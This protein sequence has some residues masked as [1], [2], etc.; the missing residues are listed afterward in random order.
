MSNHLYLIVYTDPATARSW[1][2]DEV[3]ERWQGVLPSQHKKSSSTVC[4]E[5]ITERRVCLTSL[6]RFTK[7]LNEHIARRANAEDDCTGHFWESRFRSQALLDER[8]ITAAM[9]YVDINPRMEKPK[10]SAVPMTTRF[11]RLMS[12]ESRSKESQYHRCRQESADR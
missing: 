11:S 10:G 3:I 5:W 9:A 7:L 8:A 12:N 6:S 1:S 2:D 4:A